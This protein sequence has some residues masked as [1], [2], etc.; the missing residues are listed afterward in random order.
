MNEP[1]AESVRLC[2]ELLYKDGI[3]VAYCSEPW[4]VEHSHGDE[5]LVGVPLTD[6]DHEAVVF[7]L[8]GE[9]AQVNIVVYGPAPIEPEEENKNNVQ[10][11]H[12][13]EPSYACPTCGS[14]TFMTELAEGD[15]TDTCPLC[16]PAEDDYPPRV[17]PCALCDIPTNFSYLVQ[18]EPEGGLGF[19]RSWIFLCSTHRPLKRDRGNKNA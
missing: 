10:G 19:V 11:E 18:A 5:P 15:P 13:P 2:G 7:V 12:N 14:M 4:G 17:E 8:G 9:V 6:G 16:T 1:N 3:A